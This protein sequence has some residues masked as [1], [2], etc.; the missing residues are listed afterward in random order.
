MTDTLR[1]NI[2]ELSRQKEQFSIAWVRAVVSVAGYVVYQPEVDDDSVDLGIAM[3]GGRGTIRSPRLEAQL[4]C[5]AAPIWRF[6]PM[7]F[8]LKKKNYDDLRGNDLLVPRIL[9]VVCVPEDVTLWLD[10]SEERMILQRCGYYLSLRNFPP[11]PASQGSVTVQIP[12]RQQ[13]TVAELRCVMEMIGKG[14]KP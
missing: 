11:R 9:I 6:D 5:T 12:R 8:V 7:Q 14:Q 10:Q 1:V 13:F 3:R 4:K 2:M